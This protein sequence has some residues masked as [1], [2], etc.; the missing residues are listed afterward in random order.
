MKKILTLLAVLVGGTTLY[1]QSGEITGKVREENGEPVM[2]ANVAIVDDAGKLTGRGVQTDMDGNYS[3]KPLRAGKYNVQFSYVGLASKI[4]TGIIVSNDKTTFQD[5]TMKVQNEL[6][7]VEVVVFKRPLIDKG[8][9]KVVTTYAAEDLKSQGIQRVENAVAQSAGVNQEDKNKGVSIRGART[10]GTTY[11][12][13][14]IKVIG[15]PTLPVSAVEE[16]QVIVGGVPAKYGDATGGVVNI[17]TKGPSGE[18]HGG[19][20]VQTSRGLDAFGYTQ[21]TASLIGPIARTKDKKRTIFG[22]SSAFEF[23]N[24]KDNTPSAVGVWQV[25]PNVLADIKNEPLIRQLTGTG[26]HSKSETLTFADLYKTSTRPN[27]SENTYRANLGLSISPVQGISL[28]IGGNVNY[29]NYHDLVN[30]YTLLNAENNPQRQELNYRGYIRFQHSIGETLK[31]KKGE[32]DKAEESKGISVEN[33]YYSIQLDFEKFKK[34]Y[35]DD[36][37]K[38]RLFNYGYIGQFQTE[39]VRNFER[40]TR[41]IDGVGYDGFIQTGTRDTAVS[42]LPGTLNPLGTK[43]TEQYYQLLG[44]TKDDKGFYHVPGNAKVGFAQNIDQV[45]QNGALINGQRSIPIYNMWYNVGRQYNGYGFDNNDE[46]YHGRAEASFDIVKGGANTNR[47]SIEIG[48]EYEQRNQRS[49]TINPLY[50]WDIARTAV[51]SNLV[52]DT[53]NPIFV[54]QGQQ[55]TRAT[56]KNAPQFFATDSILYNYAK[57]PNQTQSYFDYNLR[58]ALNMDYT[59]KIDL[60]NTDVNKLNIGLFSADEILRYTPSAAGGSIIS[61][62][63][64]DYTGKVI[65]QK[66]TLDGFF[67]DKNADGQFTRLQGAFQPIYAAGYIQD[68][69]FFKDIGIVAG[70]R[71]DHFDANQYV[72]RD[73]Y[74]LY[75]IKTKSETQQM[76]K[77]D[78][79]SYSV[80]HPSNI[81]DNY[82]VYVDKYGAGGT[83][84][85]YRN[86]GD[87]YDR[88]G[89]PT[90]GR[91][92]QLESPQGI[93]PLVNLAD[94][95]KKAYQ[96]SEVI[97]SIQ[98]DN[99]IKF[100]PNASFT[101]YKA[102][103]IVM[104]RLQ[105]AFNISDKAQFFA[106]YD[107]LSQRPRN[108]NQLNLAEYLYWNNYGTKQNPNLRPEIT[109]DYEFGFKQKV[110]ERSS[111]T[112]SAY[113]K[114]FRNQVQLKKYYY[115]FPG[116]YTTY[117][118]ID[119]GSS[120]GVSLTYDFRRFY[121][122]KIMA[123]YT[124]QFAEGTGSDDQS[125]QFLINSN[126]P[127]FR[128]IVPL[129][130]DNRHTINL[131]IDYRFG[132]GKEYNGPK[133]KNG[134][135]ILQ[136]FGINLVLLARSSA[137]Y[138]TNS[139]AQSE[140]LIGGGSRGRTT[141]VDTRLGWYFRGNLRIDKSFTFKIGKK[142][143]AEDKRTQL[144]L[145][146][147]LL[148]Q[149]L[150]DA[151][152]ALKAYRYT[153][154]PNDDGYLKSDAARVNI[155]T[156]YNAQSFMD[157]YRAAV[158]DPNNY[159]QPRTI[160]L[161]ASINF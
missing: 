27:T 11:M 159:N 142:N 45:S 52:L 14:G 112:I 36:T 91:R 126:T 57:D 23:V 16:I 15:T 93:T 90:T 13:D 105:F 38:D 70:L 17:T 98:G 55:Y 69:F 54:I 62:R 18:F 104:P 119:F 6:K 50:L 115:A 108:R 61:M 102:Q 125:S 106:H 140:A 145:Q 139:A 131:N 30:E 87:W 120:K 133:T 39:T 82:A 161:G 67:N 155:A 79:S 40:T 156:Q 154:N 127:N 138:T 37:H 19:A 42:F 97:N 80:N 117:D 152:Y 34:W 94:V 12:V 41:T 53:T 24:Q 78:G 35:Q 59:Q 95:E 146:V 88:Y 151:K 22:F 4:I 129:S 51:N 33:A 71:I 101:K 29:R 1:A 76:Y 96:R 89:N 149:N 26:F 66:T 75:D 160:F 113:Y 28:T 46:Q 147:Y 100:D 84:V 150:W 65:H 8:E 20:E 56:V 74:S 158:N 134:Y 130:Y 9:T 128:T 114:D 64:Y 49:Y 144:G 60:F 157:L 123:N 31:K 136:N 143:E 86:G 58:K 92:I 122:V 121:N 137:P 43:F 118:N 25:K 68:K 124:L 5:V 47:H 116:D 110:T 153:L 77:S 85:G 10:D 2:F 72:L 135:E 107:V 32:E 3:I 141:S 83:I 73:P 48:I 21:A 111:V 99:S 44:A 63:G 81:G 103:Y 109:I 148:I 7:E 132:E